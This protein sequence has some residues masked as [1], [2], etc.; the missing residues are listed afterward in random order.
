MPCR[1][2]SCSSGSDH[3]SRPRRRQDRS[4]CKCHSHSRTLPRTLVRLEP[5]RLQRR[6][7]ALWRTIVR[8]AEDHL[9]QLRMFRQCRGDYRPSN[10]PC[11]RCRSRPHLHKLSPWHIQ[12][13][14][15]YTFVLAGYD[16]N[17]SNRMIPGSC[18]SPRHFSRP[19]RY[20]R[21]RFHMCSYSLRASSSPHWGCRSRCKV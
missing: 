7:S 1:D 15:Y 14:P 12:R 18:P 2:G 19:R 16:K 21:C 5:Y 4:R 3:R 20:W 11:T 10:F 13:V 17:R 8:P 9:R 6:R